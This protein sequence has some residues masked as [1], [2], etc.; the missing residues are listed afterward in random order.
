MPSTRAKKTSSRKKITQKTLETGLPLEKSRN[1]IVKI[2]IA[3]LGG[4][5]KTSLCQRAMGRILDD[6]FSNYKVTIGVQFFTHAV[7]TDKGN[8][9][10]SVWD[11]A[12][13]PQFQQIMDRFLIGSKG[14]I[15]AFDITD[16]NSFFS[17]YH[18]WIPLIKEHCEKDIP[19]LLISTKN[20][21][22]ENKQ[23]DEELISDFINSKE[24]HGLNIIGYYETS[25]KSNVNVFET[26]ETLC[27]RIISK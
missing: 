27:K 6:Y 19:I 10:L 25:S 3:G 20:D 15:L 24:N 16:I 1:P 5:G 7:K 13:Q 12:G 11:L 23:I 4:V 9:V 14:V 2:S 17:L 22:S 21:M 8:V 18:S 26:F